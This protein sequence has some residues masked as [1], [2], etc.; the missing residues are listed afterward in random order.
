MVYYEL[1]EED[2]KKVLKQYRKLMYMI[3]HRIGGDR[4]AHD[5]DDNF[6]ELSTACMEAITT[7]AR[8]VDVEFDVFFETTEFDKYIKTCLWNKKNNVGNRIKKKYGIRNT[9]S[10]S[11]SPESLND[12]TELEQEPLEVSALDDVSLDTTAKNVLKIIMSDSKLIKPDGKI[13]ISKLSSQLGKTK[14]ETRF[15]LEKIEHQLKDYE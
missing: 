6:Q 3:A 8:K 1:K 11:G 15:L 7:Y 2:W 12:L 14:T 10:L 9:M 4:V 5:F 13:N